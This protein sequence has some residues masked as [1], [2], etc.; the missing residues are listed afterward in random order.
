M[1]Q[2]PVVKSTS[3]LLFAEKSSE[4]LLFVSDQNSL[5]VAVENFV[6]KNGIMENENF[7]SFPSI[8]LRC[9]QNKN[10]TF[11]DDING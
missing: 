3:S 9:S 1:K 5:G 2:I 8:T 10:W 7:P 6:K 11:Q 4:K